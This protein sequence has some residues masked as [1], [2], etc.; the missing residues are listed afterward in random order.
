M[1]FDWPQKDA[2]N[3][4][5]F[6]LLGDL[7]QSQ[8]RNR[9]IQKLA[10]MTPTMQTKVN[11]LAAILENTRPINVPSTARGFMEAVY[12]LLRALK[13]DGA[14]ILKS[15]WHILLP[16]AVKTYPV[17]PDPL[18]DYEQQTDFDLSPEESG[19]ADNKLFPS[20]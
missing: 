10:A 1:P 2:E 13:I 16:E 4:A 19:V 14:V 8:G 15:A 5:V 12:H 20:P 18:E 17:E 9:S 7:A 11:N 3:R 6:A